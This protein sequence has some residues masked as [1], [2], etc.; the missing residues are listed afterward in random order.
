MPERVPAPR[1][2][3][4]PL[5]AGAAAS[6]SLPAGPI[7]YLQQNP[8]KLESKSWARYEKYKRARDVAEFV[9]LGGS[10]PDLLYD[11]R[12][13]FVDG[14]TLA[15]WEGGLQAKAPKP[16]AGRTFVI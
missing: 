1:G 3:S 12:H 2:Q 10:R 11:F 7:A 4:S 6:K 13:G 16:K 14:P 5:P 15:A 9:A 8:K